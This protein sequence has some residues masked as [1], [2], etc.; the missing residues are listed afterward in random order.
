[1]TDF[2]EYSSIKISKSS[3]TKWFRSF[4]ADLRYDC[5]SLFILFALVTL[6]MD[7]FF[8]LRNVNGKKDISKNTF[9]TGGNSKLDIRLAASV[10]KFEALQT[11]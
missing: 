5:G 11:A 7:A 9:F 4:R 8:E 2:L 3:G 1:M 6:C 10:V